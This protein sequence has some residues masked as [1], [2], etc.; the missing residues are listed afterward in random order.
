MPNTPRSLVRLEGRRS[1][2]ALVR[3]GGLVSITDGGRALLPR[4]TA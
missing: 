2:A 3:V 1:L 4:R